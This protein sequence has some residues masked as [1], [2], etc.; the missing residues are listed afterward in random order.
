[1]GAGT[2]RLDLSVIR[3]LR[4]K[5]G[6]TGE[7]FAREANLTRSTV[8]KI[9]AGNGNPTIETLAAMAEVFQLRPSELVRMA[10]GDRLEGGVCEPFV[11]PG[12]R[13]IRMRFLDFELFHLTADRGI[14]I[15]SEPDLHENTMELCLVLKGGLILTV[16]GQSRELDSGTG[17][18]YNA[19]H[20]HQLTVIEDTEFILIHH[21]LT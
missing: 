14:K 1:M 8:A 11:R 7:E 5:K 2:K 17:F 15:E 13:G 3:N 4:I 21:V 20:E 6:L 19:L 9:E 16:G 10:E 12:Y 18:R